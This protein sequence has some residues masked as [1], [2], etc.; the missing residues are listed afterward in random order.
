MKVLR[1][2]GGKRREERSKKKKGD[3]RNHTPQTHQVI[4]GSGNF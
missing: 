2:G 3:N 1:K 4:K